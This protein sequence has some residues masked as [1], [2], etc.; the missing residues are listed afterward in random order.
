MTQ[1]ICE[2][3]NDTGTCYADAII[4]NL[5]NTI[6]FN[7]HVKKLNKRNPIVRE[8]QQIIDRLETK[9]PSSLN[10]LV[11]CFPENAGIRGYDVEFLKYLLNELNIPF[12]I[13]DIPGIIEGEIIFIP[14]LKLIVVAMPQNRH[15]SYTVFSR[16]IN[17]INPE[18]LLHNQLLRR[19]L[20]NFENI[21]FNLIGINKGI[22]Y[23]GKNIGHA[24]AYI[25]KR[26]DSCWWECNDERIER[27]GSG[28]YG[29]MVQNLY[30]TTFGT[31]RGNESSCGTGILFFEIRTDEDERRTAE[32]RSQKL[33]LEH[34]FQHL[35]KF[36][37]KLVYL[38][39]FLKEKFHINLIDINVLIK[40]LKNTTNAISGSTTH[41]K[42]ITGTG[43]RVLKDWYIERLMRERFSQIN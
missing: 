3:P 2:F 34:N 30:T 24:L 18:I 9:H 38:I 42:S 13:T 17:P 7:K 8:L 41:T 1:T 22:L 14:L 21:H 35:G 27:I 12:T 33:I 15:F 11:S 20:P 43:F 4:Q 28:S 37:M 10:K 26:K 25:K 40:R 23:H 6:G 36:P 19:N 32:I 16:I 39:P 31:S 29:E 5:L